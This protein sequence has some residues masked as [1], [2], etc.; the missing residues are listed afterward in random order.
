M[1]SRLFLS[2]LFLLATVTG[3][4]QQRPPAPVDSTFYRPVSVPVHLKPIERGPGSLGILGGTYYYG[5]KRLRIPG[6]LEIPFSELNDP[7]VL[8]HFGQYRLFSGLGRAASL[9]PLIYLLSQTQNRGR[10]SSDSYWAV[11][12]GSVAASLTL[13]LVGNGQFNKA[14][15][16]Y[17]RRLAGVP[18]VGLS[19]TPTLPL[20]PLAVGPAVS[21]L[22]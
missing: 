4:A 11:Y 3:Q 20:Q 8:R 16:T 9:V 18:S 21:W 10:F 6:S 13:V 15:T 14:V 1:Q 12:F 2:F 7:T 17:N 19:A 5:G 22:F